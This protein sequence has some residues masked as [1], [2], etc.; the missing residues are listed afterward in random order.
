MQHLVAPV[1]FTEHT[2]TSYNTSP[3]FI[4]F[5]PHTPFPSTTASSTHSLRP[6]PRFIRS[7]ISKRTLAPTLH[8]PNRSIGR[9][10]ATR[11]VTLEARL[12][13]I[14]ISSSDLT[15]STCGSFKYPSQADIDTSDLGVRGILRPLNDRV[16]PNTPVP[17]VR[18]ADSFLTPIKGKKR[19]GKTRSPVPRPAEGDILP[20]AQISGGPRWKRLGA[21]LSAV[22][23]DASYTP[24][25]R[26]DSDKT[27]EA[28]S[29]CSMSVTASSSDSPICFARFDPSEV[30][31]S[32]PLPR[33]R[34]LDCS[35]PS[36][37]SPY[38]SSR[39]DSSITEANASAAEN[40][41]GSTGG[42]FGEEAI[43]EGCSA[44]EALWEYGSSDGED[45]PLDS[46]IRASPVTP[47]IEKAGIKEDSMVMI[48]TAESEAVNWDGSVPGISGG[49]E[50]R[51][52]DSGKRIRLVDSDCS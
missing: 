8:T 35:P 52:V 5:A 11:A 38:S 6:P 4:A 20:A 17:T 19:Y 26:L 44:L 24:S 33:R 39:A 21:I 42:E 40:T 47:N 31:S 22:D 1:S 10:A 16:P 2:D 25:R 45:S 23:E 32:T 3:S 50:N 34:P 15:A 12:A 37:D 49:N 28:V 14:S 46:P 29:S 18:F 9:A 51:H 48:N 36:I 13:D 41:T 7:P 27:E 30:A 43:F